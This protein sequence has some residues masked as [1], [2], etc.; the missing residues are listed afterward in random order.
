LPSNN[1]DEYIR[2]FRMFSHISC[3]KI[4]SK[5]YDVLVIEGRRDLG[6]IIPAYILAEVEQRTGGIPLHALFHSFIGIST[7]AFI[8]GVLSM[9]GLNNN[10]NNQIFHPE[11]HGQYPTLWAH[12][13]VTRDN[14]RDAFI[15]GQW[16][17]VLENIIDVNVTMQQ[18][19]NDLAIITQM[20]IYSNLDSPRENTT[21]AIVS[22]ILNLEHEAIV[23]NNLP[24][25]LGNRYRRAN[26]IVRV[27]SFGTRNIPPMPFTTS[28]HINL[29][30]YTNIETIQNNCQQ[31]IEN[32]NEQI[33]NMVVALMQNL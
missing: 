28:F 10:N 17:Q 8:A 18:A 2:D 31:F 14:I 29:D 5:F 33:Q 9:P 20:A 21:D 13:I 6:G 3:H 24:Y 12:D 22:S 11:F 25:E 23:P 26:Q 32:N 4:S 27:W 16:Q 19:M 30:N 7:G 15:T 1:I